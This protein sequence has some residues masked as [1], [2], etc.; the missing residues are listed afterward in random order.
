MKGGVYRMLTVN[1]SRQVVFRIFY[2]EVG[3]EEH[4]PLMRGIVPY[5]P[6]AAL[7]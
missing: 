4:H 3:A 7:A 6:L 2:F 5:I 1:H